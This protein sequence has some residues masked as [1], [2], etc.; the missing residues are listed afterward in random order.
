MNISFVSG[1]FLSLSLIVAIGPQNAFILR[2]GLLRQ[3]VLLVALFCAI[4]DIILILLGIFGFGSLILEISW[5]SSYMFIVGG[6]WLLGYGLLRLKDAYV[7]DSYLEISSTND[8]DLKVTLTNCAALTWL[9]PHVYIDTLVMI[10]TISTQY[11]DA[12]QFGLGACLASSFFFFT[13]AFGARALS[14]I[15]KSRKA[16]QSLDVI[17]AMIMFTLSLSM[18]SE[19]F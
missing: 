7:G 2:Q 9:N 4:S 8:Q 13:L 12:F 17:I 5:L 6:I 16:W 10:G 3:H 19:S 1:F 11:E 14:P 18:F 15:M